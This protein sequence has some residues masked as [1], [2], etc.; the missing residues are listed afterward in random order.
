MSLRFIR[1]LFS[2]CKTR[3]LIIIC[4][5]VVLVRSCI[6]VISFNAVFNAKLRCLGCDS[7]SVGRWLCSEF[8]TLNIQPFFF[9]MMTA[10]KEYSHERLEVSHFQNLE[11]YKTLL[12]P[13]R[14]LP[15][16]IYIFLLFLSFFSSKRILERRQN[17]LRRNMR[18]RIEE[19]DRRIQEEVISCFL[20]DHLSLKNS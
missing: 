5:G 11:V 13:V 15:F 18:H 14:V 16:D 8:W 12:C 1:G 20:Q 7:G 2:S 4:I 6:F 9:E 3:A 19:K 17:N 10:S